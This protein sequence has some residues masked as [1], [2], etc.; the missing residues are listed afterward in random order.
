MINIEFTPEKDGIITGE[1]NTF[2]VLLRASSN[3]KQPSGSTKKLPLNLA[4]VLDRSGSMQGHPLEEAK[5]C[6]AMLVDRMSENDMLSVTTYDSRV[7]V[8]IPTTKVVNKNL[9]KNKI[10]Q[11]NS[12]GTTALYDGWSIGAEQVAEFADNNSLSRVLLLSDGQA[13]H[14]LTDEETITS[15]CG[16]MA[17]NGVTTSTYGL[18]PRF[19]ENLMSAMATAGQGQSHY[20][21]TADDLMD[22]FSEEFDLMEAIIARRMRLRISPEVGVSFELLNHYPTDQEGRFILPDLAY[23]A[24]VWALLKIKVTKNLCDAARGTSLRLLTATIDFIDPDGTEVRT[25]PSVMTIELQSPDAYAELMVDET[26]HQRSIEL[27]AATLHEQA[28]AAAGDGDWVRID[29]I[30]EELEQLGAGNAWL[31]ASIQ[32]LRTYSQTRRRDDFSKEARYKSDRMRRRSVSRYENMDSY[33]EASENAQP[34]YLRRKLEQGK[35]QQ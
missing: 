6:A 17:E 11:I 25:D 4:L 33:S 1:E 26:V 31:K 30:M 14:G 34:S 12:G 5:K 32:R 23:G 8:I 24:D 18:G 19:N 21:Q 16:T 3:Q 10:N 29:H 22:P 7:D 15:H 2:E 27:R 13:N 20:G 9:L 28:H 35:K